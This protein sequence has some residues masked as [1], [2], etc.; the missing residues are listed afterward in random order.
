VEEVLLARVPILKL[1]FEGHL[2]V[3]LSCHNTKPLENS[4]LLR[5]YAGMDDRVRDLGIA[6]KLWAKAAQVCGASQSHLSSYAFT[7]MAIYFMQ[8]APD[9]RLPR[10]P[11]NAFEPNGEGV[12]DKRVQT[13]RKTWSCS[14]PLERLVAGF[15]HFYVHEFNWCSEVVSVRFGDRLD[16]HQPFFHE[17]KGRQH[18]RLHLED[19]CDP[20]R[21][22]NCALGQIEEQ[23]LYAALQ[24]ASQ[25]LQSGDTP[26][27]LEVAKEHT[28]GEPELADAAGVPELQDK[29]VPQQSEGKAF[30]GEGGAIL[31][32]G[33]S[34][35]S[36]AS[37][38]ES[39]STVV[40]SCGGASGGATAESLAV[41]D[42]REGE[43]LTSGDD[44]SASRPPPVAEKKEMRR[45]AERVQAPRAGA[46]PPPK[47]VAKPSKSSAKEGT[48]SGSQ[49]GTWYQ[50]GELEAK[51][52][53]REAPAAERKARPQDPIQPESAAR[54]SRMGRMGPRGAAHKDAAPIIF[55]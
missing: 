15:F 22:L 27:G 25:L 9:V 23:Q 30:A 28:P 53:S 49:K 41:S 24:N 19:P 4:S 16:V 39:P 17:L 12:A 37:G 14:Q 6:V 40:S 10:L 31:G 18:P 5:A 20:E 45:I 29:R 46:K 36:T 34:G 44:G 8:T 42:P 52:M 55:Q 1:C 32:P 43:G 47:A 21:N 33:S 51:M 38:S 2:E 26:V 11:A 54:R 7:L 35:E 3:D 50:C 48:T 13:A